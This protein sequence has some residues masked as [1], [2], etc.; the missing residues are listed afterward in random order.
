MLVSICVCVCVLNGNA[1]GYVCYVCST[2]KGECVHVSCVVEA[3]PPPFSVS[4]SVVMKNDCVKRENALGCVCVCM[5]GVCV[6]S[7]C[8]KR[9]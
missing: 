4:S 1:C 9:E 2:L 7:K 5:W 6:C 3:E 8:C